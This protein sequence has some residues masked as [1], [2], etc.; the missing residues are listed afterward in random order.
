MLSSRSAAMEALNSLSLSHQRL[1]GL[2]SGLVT[3]LFPGDGT[4]RDE[5]ILPFASL[6]FIAVTKARADLDS[7]SK[8]FAEVLKTID[9]VRP[10]PAQSSS[11]ENLSIQ[12]APAPH[13]VSAGAPPD[14]AGQNQ[15]GTSTEH[16]SS[17]PT[18]LHAR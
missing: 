11:A 8:S 4:T 10:P 16:Y 15:S 12:A 18:I 13:Y 17:K 3:R 5:M 6:A 2:A 9:L 1:L 7:Y 14:A